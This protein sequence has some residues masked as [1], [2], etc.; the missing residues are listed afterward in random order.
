MGSV[1]ERKALQ[2]LLPEEAIERTSLQCHPMSIAGHMNESPVQGGM[3]QENLK[4][5]VRIASQPT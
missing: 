4:A 1:L 5:P 3:L 2:Q